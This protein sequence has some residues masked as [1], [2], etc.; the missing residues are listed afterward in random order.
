VIRIIKGNVS[1]IDGVMNLYHNVQD[2]FKKRN[3]DIYQDNEYPNRDIFL[4]DLSRQDDTLLLVDNDK[5]IGFMTSS[6]G[7]EFINSI[8][9]DKEK[10]DKFIEKYKL[11][12]YE[13]RIVAY[14][15]LMINSEYRHQGYGSKLMTILDG[16]F[17]GSF[18][19]FLVHEVNRNAIK[20]YGNL[21]YKC[22]GLEDFDFGK[23]YVFT[24]NELKG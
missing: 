10:A 7:N 24:K 15:R 5:V 18:I 22:L 8:F 2:D 9:D 19:I 1:Y 23:Y 11:K 3:I 21:G 4:S 13:G 6:N 16:R 17:K 12:D 14:E 20:L